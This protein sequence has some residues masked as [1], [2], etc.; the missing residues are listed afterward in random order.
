MLRPAYY[1]ALRRLPGRESH[2]LK[3]RS[4]KMVVR[5]VLRANDHLFHDAPRDHPTTDRPR[6]RCASRSLLDC[7]RVS[8]RVKAMQRLG[9][10]PTGELACRELDPEPHGL[11][12]P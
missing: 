11:A 2:P 9:S 10:K 7:H 6:T 3:K 1:P 12:G 5:P 4:L 8:P